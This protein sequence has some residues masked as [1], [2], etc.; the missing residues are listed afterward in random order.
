MPVDSVWISTANRTWTNTA[1][2][3]AGAAP[4]TGDALVFKNSSIGV[5]YY[6]AS[7]ITLGSVRFDSDYTGLVPYDISTN[8]YFKLTVPHLIVGMAP[9]V[10][11]GTGSGRLALN[12]GSVASTVDVFST[13]QV[14]TDANLMPLRLLGTALTLNVLGGSVSVAMDEFE[15][16]TIAALTLSGGTVLLG[17]NCLCTSLTLGAGTVSTLG[18]IPTATVE[19]GTLSFNGAV[20][21]TTLTINGGTC[22]PNAAGTIGTLALK[23]TLDLSTG[24][25]TLTITNPVTL[26]AG[27]VIR[28]PLGRLATSTQFV[29][30]GCSWQDVT[31]IGKPGQTFEIAA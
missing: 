2:W 27:A 15:T 4:T 6:D 29:L 20:T 18:T 1:N 24:T 9:G 21:V 30:S 14:A 31:Y 19:S 3:S 16:A 26:Y 22:A 23:G 28:D 25:G 11:A 12:L 17:K 13:S 7:A 8:S 5:D 10:S